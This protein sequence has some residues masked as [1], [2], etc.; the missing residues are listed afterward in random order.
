MK[1]E[2]KFALEW[3][4]T[5]DVNDALRLETIRRVFSYKMSNCTLRKDKAPMCIELNK[6]PLDPA[7]EEEMKMVRY[8]ILISKVKTILEKEHQ[9]DPNCNVSGLKDEQ[10]REID[11]AE[12]ED[13]KSNDEDEGETDDVEDADDENDDD[14]DDNDDSGN[15]GD[16]KVDPTYDSESPLLVGPD[17][18]TVPKRSAAQKSPNS[19]DTREASQEVEDV[20]IDHPDDLSRALVPHVQPT[21]ETPIKREEEVVREGK[22]EASP[23]L[24]SSASGG[25]KDA[26][27]Q[28][29][30]VE[31]P[32]TNIEDDSPPVSPRKV[33]NLK[34][35]TVHAAKITHQQYMTL[36]QWDTVVLEN[37]SKKVDRLMAAQ[38]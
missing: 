10:C 16:N 22:L 25:K 32:Q 20:S 12:E 28:E 14:D 5:K 30:L 35:D 19:D 11:M 37:L 27:L 36:R 17:Y 18:D 33:I 34:R 29:D 9:N 7:F 24:L 2:E 13:E 31:T 23:I 15:D 26:P 6:P 21:D 3:I 8:A 38:A 4:D 1:D